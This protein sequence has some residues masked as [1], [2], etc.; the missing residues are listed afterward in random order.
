MKLKR[1]I[2][3]DRIQNAV[4]DAL[5]EL[6]TE[7]DIPQDDPD[8]SRRVLRAFVHLGIRPLIRL[9]APPAFQLGCCAQAIG[10]EMQEQEVEQ[11]PELTLLSGDL[12][13]V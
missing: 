5:G 4:A 7:F 9:G 1:K 13:E 3:E 6:Q 10:R 8:F 2:I 12:E 11:N